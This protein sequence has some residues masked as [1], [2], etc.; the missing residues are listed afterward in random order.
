MEM[1]SQQKTKPV[2]RKPHYVVT[3]QKCQ[4]CSLRTAQIYN[5]VTQ[6]FRCIQCYEGPAP[7][8]LC[9]NCGM[10]ELQKLYMNKKDYNVEHSSKLI[11]DSIDCYWPKIAVECNWDVES[12]VILHLAREVKKEMPVFTVLTPFTPQETLKFKD[13]VIKEWGLKVKEYFTGLKVPWSLH[14]IKPDLCCKILKE[15]P[16]TLATG[17]FECSLTSKTNYA[18]KPSLVEIN[19]VAK[20]GASAIWRYTAA[21]QIPVNPLYSKGFHT[22][23]CL[24]CSVREVKYI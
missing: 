3:T 6:E 2:L 14:L 13:A 4:K 16:L 9:L 10:R 11:Q 21:H 12:L 5:P 1:M 23:D 22:V 20:W 7:L 19:P 8:E 24:P 15:T 17:N 18:E